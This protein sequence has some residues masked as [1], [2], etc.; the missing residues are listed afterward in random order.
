MA[1]I[2]FDLSSVKL[3]SVF[4]IFLSLEAEA[5][6][7]DKYL[8]FSSFSI[9][10]SSYKFSFLTSLASKSLSGSEL[11]SSSGVFF[12]VS[13]HFSIRVSKFSFSKFEDDIDDFFLPI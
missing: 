11:N 9:W 1:R 10:V 2:K 7:L 13:I 12:V 4:T 5:S 6:N 8:I 3:D